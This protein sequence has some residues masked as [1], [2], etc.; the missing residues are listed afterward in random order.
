MASTGFNTS[1]GAYYIVTLPLDATGAAPSSS[2]LNTL[3][4]AGANSG[5]AWVGPTFA[6]AKMSTI[7]GPACSDASGAD[8]VKAGS[9]LKDMGKSVVSSGRVFRKFAPVVSGAAG[10]KDS[11]GVVGSAASAPNTGYASFYLE[12]GREGT[13]A[14]APVA[15]YC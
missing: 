10:G 4:T 14:P 15:R 8:L 6:K 2:F 3:A 13:G 5:G 12:V 1:G 7:V 9:L 11:F